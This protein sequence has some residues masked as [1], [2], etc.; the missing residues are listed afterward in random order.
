[1]N[2]ADVPLEQYTHNELARWLVATA[3]TRA[4][5][6]RKA[7]LVQ[8]WAAQPPEKLKSVA[9]TCRD[10]L[11]AK[12]EKRRAISAARKKDENERYSA[13]RSTKP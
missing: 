5:D 6:K 10:I 4:S 13:A 2:W 7:E 8:A 3:F 11:A 1:M 12:Q 9:Y